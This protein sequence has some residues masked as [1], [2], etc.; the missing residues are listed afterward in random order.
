VG[1]RVRPPNA[2]AP[3]R[4]TS[5]ESLLRD[6]NDRLR[7]VERWNVDPRPWVYVAD[8][9]PDWDSALTYSPGDQVEDG[10]LVFEAWKMSTDVEP[11]VDP[12]WGGFW[13]VVGPPFQNGWTN[14][15][16]PDVKM[17]YRLLR[18]YAERGDDTPGELNGVEIQGSV[19][20]GVPGSTIFTLGFPMWTP[21]GRAA[22]Q[23]FLPDFKLHLAACDS[24]G[25]FIVCTV[26]T[27]GDVI[28]GFS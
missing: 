19:F 26:D 7:E 18:P 24:D 20:N 9:S 10:G 2:T 12:D 4:E 5:G 6:L 27:S 25:D 16:L 11:G 15:G 17:R 1:D 13:Y 14:I 22:W 28:H 8:A 21:D 3:I 23:T